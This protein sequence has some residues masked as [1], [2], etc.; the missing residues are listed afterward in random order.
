MCIEQA[1][2]QLKVDVKTTTQVEEGGEIF[3]A[4]REQGASEYALVL[5]D[6]RP[7]CYYVFSSLRW[8]R[9]CFDHSER[10]SS[11]GCAL[12]RACGQNATYSHL[13]HTLP[14]KRV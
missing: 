10:G 7:L 11:C 9:F 3:G 4:V 13:L 5:Q 6:T 1:K 14:Y 8:F 2:T 12:S